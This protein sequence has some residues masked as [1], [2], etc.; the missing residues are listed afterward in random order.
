MKR[1]SEPTHYTVYLHIYIYCSNDD[2][3]HTGIG[4]N[5]FMYTVYEVFY[6]VVLFPVVVCVL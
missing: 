6:R 2:V 3:L 5:G 4:N 1:I